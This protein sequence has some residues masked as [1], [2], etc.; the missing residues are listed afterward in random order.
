MSMALT[1]DSNSGLALLNALLSYASLHRHGLNEQA[2]KLKIQAIHYLSASVTSEA[3]IL[4][5]AAQHVAASM[6]LGAFEVSSSS[7]AIISPLCLI[8]FYCIDN[9]TFGRLRRV[10][11]AHMGGC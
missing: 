11:F 8:N 5:R 6:V 10:A 2:L 3:L 1:K 9:A 4:G 7:V